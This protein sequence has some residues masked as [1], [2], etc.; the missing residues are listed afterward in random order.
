MYYVQKKA[1]F[2]FSNSIMA[3]CTCTMQINIIS[4]SKLNFELG[5]LVCDCQVMSRDCSKLNFEHDGWLADAYNLA[6]L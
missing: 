5:W 1:N 6:K 3:E 2:M 4:V